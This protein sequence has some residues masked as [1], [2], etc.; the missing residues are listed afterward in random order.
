[1][2]IDKLVEHCHNLLPYDWK[3]APWTRL[4]HGYDALDTEDK[5]NAYI[6]AYG[7]M[8]VTKCRKAMQNFPFED[9][10]IKDKNGN[11]S[12]FIKS[13]EVFDWGCGQGLGALTFIELLQQRSMLHG[14][15]KITLIEP[16]PLALR[17]AESWVR[18]STSPSTEVKTVQRYIPTDRESRWTD[19]DWDTKIA[20]HIFSNILDIRN[21]DLRWLAETTSKIGEQNY[22]ICVGPKYGRGVSRIDD[23][24]NILNRPEA[25]ADF[26]LFPCG[27]T[28]RTQHPFGIE[29]KCFLHDRNFGVDNY[30]LELS[31]QS[32]MDE[33]QAGDECLRGVVANEVIEAYHNLRLGISGTSE[34]YFMP[35]VGVERPDFMFMNSSNGIVIINVCKD[36]AKFSE[37]FERVEAIKN[38]LFDIY[39]KS[40]KISSIINPR[41][42]NAIKVGLYFP[43]TIGSEEIKNA[44]TQHYKNLIEKF[45]KNNPQADNL[46]K[47]STKYLVELTPENAQHRLQTMKAQGFRY[48]F[49]EEIKEIIVGRWHSYTQGDQ[50][51]T[52]TKRQTELLNNDSTRLRIKGVAGCGKTRLI[53]YKAVREHLRTG[54]RV[55]IVTYN[56]T[57]VKYIKMR[58]NEVPKEFSTDVF[59]VIN[60]HQFFWSKAKRYGGKHLH[61][62]AQDDVNFFSPFFLEIKDN[63]DQYE[64]I[65]VDEVQDFMT[66]WLDILRIYFLKD[67]G[68]FI[69]LGDGE[70]NIF[71]R[72]LEKEEKMP[73]VNGFHGRW[74]KISDNDRQIKRQLNGRLVD[75]ISQFAYHY[76]ISDKPLILDSESALNLEENYIKYGYVP[77]DI[78]QI[79][80]YSI[81]VRTLHKFNFEHKDTVILAPSIEVLRVVDYYFR[82][83][84]ISTITTFE[85]L[86][87]YEELI[88][89]HG[90][91]SAYL[92]L[93]LKAVRRVAKVH[94]TT[95][96]TFLKLATIQ[97]FKGWEAKNILLLVQSEVDN[98]RTSNKQSFVIQRHENMDALLYTGLSRARMNLVI[99]NLG[100]V[101]YHDFFK[102]NI[103]NE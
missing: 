88:K 85:T 51:F 79:K 16:S 80:L 42:Y 18:Q 38:A 4:N 75:L 55:L 68:R 10:W 25:F 54:K 63:E 33:Y 31:S 58:I 47:D 95:D 43:G 66:E 76:A 61:L 21:I 103:K 26:S 39:I 101:K 1:M 20:V 23:F 94:F 28:K 65:I 90:V 49:F 81:I 30:Y 69:L 13:F 48:S 15:R 83:N 99:L 93:D 52:L 46:P 7:D 102:N 45:Q 17:R 84:G 19:M 64:T 78:D 91:N 97:S 8:H 74:N 2:N 62:G 36:I 82:M 77:V 57:L 98:I 6:S 50:T 92:N 72:V 73:R 34:L 67:G 86:E 27:Y 11:P 40:L 5:L 24:Y 96:T 44:K 89:K 87:Q 37:E 29:V 22:Y 100:H 41:V 59:D 60:Y 12:S 70:Q 35:T 53:A 9:L 71:N 32:Y 14:L 3:A 56:I